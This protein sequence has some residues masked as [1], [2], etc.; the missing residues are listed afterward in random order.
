[1]NWY[2]GLDKNEIISRDRSFRVALRASQS[3]E[4][5]EF[6]VAVTSD[7][8]REMAQHGRSSRCLAPMSS[9][10]RRNLRRPGSAGGRTRS[11]RSL[12]IEEVKYVCRK[13]ARELHA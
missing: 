9:T 11:K 12:R 5:R 10:R 4:P 6:D 13:H 1:M 8:M 3:A 2:A 7:A